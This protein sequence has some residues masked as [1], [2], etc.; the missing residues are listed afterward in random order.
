MF[1]VVLYPILAFCINSSAFLE[2]QQA[3]SNVLDLFCPDP[4]LSLNPLTDL[5][6][7][8]RIALGAKTTVSLPLS[9]TAATMQARVGLAGVILCCRE[10]ERMKRCLRARFDPKFPIWAPR[11]NVCRTYI[12]LG[13]IYETRAE[14]SHFPD[15]KR[16]LSLWLSTRWEISTSLMSPPVHDDRCSAGKDNAI[17]HDPRPS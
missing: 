10:R 8:S 5:A 4:D 3:P 9:Q 13:L 14:I 1:T 12:S 7:F 16:S 2:L 11:L 15:W 6:A 17:H